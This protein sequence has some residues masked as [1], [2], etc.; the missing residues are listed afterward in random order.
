MN[1]Y[2]WPFELGCPSRSFLNTFFSSTSRHI[3]PRRPSRSF[4]L[5]VLLLSQG[6][7]PFEQASFSCFCLAL[8]LLLFL[9]FTPFDAMAPCGL[10]RLQS[11]L[12]LLLL[13]LVPLAA[14]AQPSAVAGASPTTSFRPIFTVPTS[15]DVGKT[16]IPNIQDPQAVD[17][18]TVCPGYRGSNVQ[19]SDTGLT[20]DLTLAG[21]ACNVY[22]TDI[23][24]LSLT[25]EYQTHSRLHIRLVPS[26]TTSSNESYY[27]LSPDY[28]PEGSQ[29]NGNAASSDLNFSWSN[30]PSFS[31][32]VIRNSTGDVIFS[33]AG[34]QLVF[35]N[36]FL[37]F[38]TSEP[39]EYNVYGLGEVIHGFRLGNNFTRT[40]YAADVGDPIDRNLYG[41]HP[42]LLETRY[43]STDADDSHTYVTSNESSAKGSY[44]SYSHG[45]FLRNAHGQEILMRENNITW[46]TIGGSMDLYFFAGPSQPEV[47]RQYQDVIGYPAMQQ[48]FTFGF[49]QCRWGYDNWTVVEDVVNTY[50]NFGLPLENIWTDIDYMDQYRDFTVDPI[51]YNQETGQAFLQRLHDGGRHFVPI[52]DAAI[53]VPNPQNGSDAYETFNRGNETSSWL[54]N[55]DGSLY[56]GD[57]WPGY[58]VFP[59][60]LSQ[61]GNSFWGT[62]LLEWHKEVSFDG[63]W[64]D[65]NEASSFCVGSCGSSNITMNPVHPPFPLPG[66][67]GNVIYDYPEGFNLTNATEAASASAASSSQAASSSSSSSASTSYFRP[68]PTPGTR[69][70]NYPP[71]VSHGQS[72]LCSCPLHQAQSD[73]DQEQTL[74]HVQEGADLSVHA[75]SP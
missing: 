4:Y 54:L 38:V 57:V 30:D 16:L 66:E 48:Y 61:A 75:V 36:Q 62:E 35:E 15:A 3:G 22:G 12:L 64:I 59:D 67:P 19:Y 33:T 27:L 25:V 68:M 23:E 42:T 37:E 1:A 39:P 24:S 50:T 63:A 46:R 34:S 51:R 11:V 10:H 58:T 53:Y 69:N 20:A 52:I 43:Y 72:S 5:P 45:V 74:N 8:Y 55:P 47:T 18:Q 70:V 28:V 6:K 13:L 41:S 40:L 65:M 7:P 56:I 17:A 9:L 60:L 49:H 29:Q 32:E 73:A 26:F 31:F 21:P 14:N 2:T 44:T 71:Y